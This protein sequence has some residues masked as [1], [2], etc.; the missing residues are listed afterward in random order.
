MTTDIYSFIN[1]RDIRKYLR[2]TEY[3]F[4]SLEAAWIIWQSM[5]RTWEEKKAAWAE[6]IRTMPDCEVP[7][8]FNCNYRASLHGYLKDYMAVKD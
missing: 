2:E 1:S 8:R 4:S 6:L 3:H 7:E 5:D